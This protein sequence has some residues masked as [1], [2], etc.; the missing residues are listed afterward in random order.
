MKAKHPFL[1]ELPPESVALERM[2]D[3]L[4]HRKS[5]KNVGLKY[6]MRAYNTFNA[7][8]AQERGLLADGIPENYRKALQRFYADEIIHK[9]F[10]THDG[11]GK[12]MDFAA[13]PAGWKMT[14]TTGAD[15]FVAQLTQRCPKLKKLT[16]AARKHALDWIAAVNPCLRGAGFYITSADRINENWL[17]AALPSAGGRVQVALYQYVPALKEALLPGPGG[18]DGLPKAGPSDAYDCSL[19]SITGPDVPRRILLRL[20][21]DGKRLSIPGLTV[22]VLETPAG[23]GPIQRG[24]ARLEPLSNLP[25]RLLPSLTLAGNR[26]SGDVDVRVRFDCA[27]AFERWLIRI[28]AKLADNRITGTF[29][30]GV[31]SPGK[32]PTPD[33]FAGAAKRANGTTTGLVAV[34]KDID[35]PTRRVALDRSSQEIGLPASGGDPITTEYPRPLGPDGSGAAPPYGKPLVDSLTAAQLVWSA[36]QETPGSYFDAG[37]RTPAHWFGVQGGYASPVIANGAVYLTY[38]WPPVDDVFDPKYVE[39]H[40]NMNLNANNSYYYPAGPFPREVMARKASISAHDVVL[41]L[42]G[43]TGRT[44]WKATFVRK[45]GNHGFQGR[46]A[47]ISTKTGPVCDAVTAKGRVYHLGS[48]GRVYCLDAKT[49]ALFWESTIG[50]RHDEM[51]HRKRRGHRHK[52]PF[53]SGYDLCSAPALAGNAVVLN[54]HT[55]YKG[56][57][58]SK[59]C[60]LVALDTRTGK[61]MWARPELCGGWLISSPLRWA[62]G[63]Q[64]FVL[65]HSADKLYC[66]DWRTGK[67][68]WEIAGVSYGHKTVVDQDHLLFNKDGALSCYRI[69]PKGAEKLWQ[70]SKEGTGTGLILGKFAFFTGAGALCLNLATGAELGQAPG[71]SIMAHAAGMDDR[72]FCEAAMVGTLGVRMYGL[73]GEAGLETLGPVL[74]VPICNCT[75][76]AVADG[77]IVVRT[78]DSIYC[79][80]LRKTTGISNRDME[81]LATA[82]R[83]GDSLLSSAATRVYASFGPAAVKPLC[84]EQNTALKTNN[85]PLFDKITDMLLGAGTEG[86]SGL[87]ELLTRTLAAKKQDERVLA[88]DLMARIWP[89]LPT[90]DSKAG[91]LNS[92]AKF[93]TGHD[94]IVGRAALQVLGGFGEAAAAVPPHLRTNADLS[95]LTELLT[96]TLAAEKQD[97]RVLACELMARIWPKLPTGDFKAGLLNSLAKFATGH[98]KIVG[99]AALQVLG[100]FGEAAA[101][102]APH[103]RAN[104]DLSLLTETRAVLRKIEGDKAAKPPDLDEENDDQDLDELGL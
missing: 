46:G 14:T 51:E 73:G 104:A 84:A 28:D 2:V 18:L 45:G 29:D 20:R 99:R 44:R 26:L 30:A 100:G 82:L 7:F 87:T 77:R 52:T 41:C 63:D 97:E 35:N 47:M 89:K 8:A 65:T 70:A 48:S 4:M 68:V 102:V 69:S 57:Q 17:H 74:N 76:P 98:D 10:Q 23:D 24:Y 16:G 86:A 92:L 36:E 96:R 58:R 15:D 49:G 31:V 101:A 62:H 11:V 22:L 54:D 80:D 55:E 94:K 40:S 66:L 67:T 37:G 90:D 9:Q 95:L 6:T 21:E 32:L 78:L 50:W 33:P 42:D 71:S 56:G 25:Q 81:L 59:R 38:Y 88:C 19:P 79:Y 60:G 5:D 64:E 34:G 13:I 3:Y 91:L 43:A 53:G 85:M 83:S 75:S 103:L 27:G 39:D 93:A 72:I 61:Q 12:G 1:S